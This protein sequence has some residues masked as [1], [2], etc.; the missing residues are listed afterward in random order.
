MNSSKV[1]QNIFRK[2]QYRY[3]EKRLSSM[4]NKAN[5]HLSP[6]TIEHKT[7]HEK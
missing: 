3:P 6:Q 5:N 2:R 1:Q 4:V 7:D